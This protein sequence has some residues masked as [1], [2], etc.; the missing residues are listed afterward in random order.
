MI[1]PCSQGLISVGLL[2]VLAACGTQTVDP[3][4]LLNSSSAKMQDLKGFHFQMDITG[5]TAQGVPVSRAEG[6]AHPP[7]LQSRVDLKEGGVLLEVDVV[8]VQG[9]LYLKSFTGGWQKLSA[10]QV[11]ALFDPH[12]L[13][14]SENGLFAAL[15][16]TESPVSSGTQTLESRTT[17]V[18][19]GKLP[20]SRAHRLLSPIRSEGTYA[21]SYWIDPSNSTLWRAVL[22]GN[23][24]DASQSSTITF[25]FSRHDQPVTVTPPVG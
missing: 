12:Q 21:A 18:V 24:F 9:Q 15:K 3:K 17:Q 25:N 19:K 8:E 1:R 22:S 13:F 10:D 16:E 11:A 6:D 23:L 14:D 7:D 4:S 2:L 5:F 20:A